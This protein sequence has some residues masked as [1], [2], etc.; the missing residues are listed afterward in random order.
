MKCPRVAAARC[1][2][3]I[4]QEGSSLARVLPRIE[5]ELDPAQ[6]SLY[7]ELCYGTLRFYW[8][9]DAAL[10]PFFSKPLKA[11]DSDVKMLIYIGAYQLSYTRIPPHAAI[12][13]CVEGCRKLKKKWASGMANAILR[14]C[15]REQDGLFSALSP[16]ASA[17]FP[18]W[19][20]NSLQNAWPDNLDDILT[21]SNSHPPFCLR[22]NQQH[23]SRTTYL[24]A[25][26]QV[27]ISASA[28]DFA[29]QGI[30][31]A[32][33]CNV[34]KLPGFHD[35][36]VSVQDEAAQLCTTLLELKPNQRVLDACAAPGGKTGAILE[37]QP[38]LSEVVALDID[39]QRLSR[40]E[41]NLN[42]LHLNATLVSAD[43]SD[44]DA[45]WDGQYFDR[46]LLD[47]P[48]SATGV[49]RR[50]PDIKLNRLDSDIEPL[51]ALQTTLL[52][53]LWQCLAPDGIFVYATCSLLPA[54]NEQ[55]L[56]AFIARHNNAELLPINTDWGVDR[57]GGRQLFPQVDGHDGFFYAKIHKNP[58]LC[59]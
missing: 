12:N 59:S 58:E 26:N 27:D 36:D 48:C 21:A 15:Q 52:D 43:A 35:G 34:D 22:V 32:Q 40:I 8:K 46:I 17:A 9:L 44:L 7:R 4:E 29:Q 11:K 54:E 41:D 6:R 13:S 51:V 37:H 24:D 10:K 42:R 57:K 38:E 18:A 3:N 2:A 30:R 55:Q 50:N 23:T 14:R 16:A 53:T 45:W 33:A 56:T 31:L 47:A 20:F 28:C 19:L 5:Q 49:I 25:L 1:L 39:E